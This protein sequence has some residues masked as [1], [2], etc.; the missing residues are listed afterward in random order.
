MRVDTVIF[1]G[2]NPFEHFAKCSELT[3]LLGENA[4]MLVGKI[5]SINLVASF[6]SI[7]NNSAGLNHRES[8]TVPLDLL[9]PLFRMDT[10]TVKNELIVTTL[11]DKAVISYNG[12][13]VT[14]NIYSP[15]GLTLQQIK[16]INWTAESHPI[17]PFID[18]LV[19]F[20]S[21]KENV[22]SV[23]GKTLLVSDNNKSLIYDGDVDYGK[24]CAVSDAFIRMARSLKAKKISLTQ[25]VV[26]TTEEGL[27]IVDNLYKFGDEAPILSYSYASKIQT[28]HKFKLNLSKYHKQFS[29]VANTKKLS[30]TLS[31]LNPYIQL[32]SEQGEEVRIPLTTAEVTMLG[33]VDFFNI[34]FSQEVLIKDASLLKSL[35]SFKEVNVKVMPNFVIARLDRAYKLI[36]TIYE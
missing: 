30:A 28:D 29:T 23:T 20:G 33:E 13:A 31:L 8:Y 24:K 17:K 2:D 19:A 12:M 6:E 5:N 34:D 7:V 4:L 35:A 11:E 9:L 16:E 3:I 36:F 15:N 25:P 14:T 26:A 1:S 21:T 18:L 10:K 32:T 27:F 22:V